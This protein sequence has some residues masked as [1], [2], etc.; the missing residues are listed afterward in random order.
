ML[1]NVPEDQAHQCWRDR[2]G[3]NRAF[4]PVFESPLLPGRPGGTGLAQTFRNPSV[5]PPGA[6]LCK[7]RNMH[8]IAVGLHRPT[9][10]SAL[11]RSET[12]AGLARAAS[13]VVNALQLSLEGADKRLYVKRAANIQ[14][15]PP[16]HGRLRRALGS[17]SLSVSTLWPQRQCLH[18]DG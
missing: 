12:H 2:H 15:S 13:A 7:I 5:W 4:G 16:G 1:V 18:T 3:V 17:V 9:Q 10:A 11:R 14:A 8:E 6:S